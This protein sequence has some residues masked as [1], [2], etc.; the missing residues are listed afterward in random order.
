LDGNRSIAP[1]LGNVSQNILQKRLPSSIL[2]S[3]SC[4]GRKELFQMITQLLHI[5]GAI[6][7]HFIATFESATISSFA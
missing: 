1:D 3:Q 5:H 6:S 4:S 2:E 7:G